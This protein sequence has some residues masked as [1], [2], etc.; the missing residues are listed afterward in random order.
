LNVPFNQTKAL[1]VVTSA[2]KALAYYSTET[3]FLH[4]PN[5]K[6]PH[7]YD[8]RLQLNTVKNTVAA[9]GYKTDWDFNLAIADAFNR[10]WDGHTTLTANCLAAFSYNLP[11][12]IATLASDVSDTQTAYPTLITNY[13]FPVRSRI[14]VYT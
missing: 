12:S 5:P 11:F 9:G 7:D 8:I 14:L 2:I 13:D 3:W 1:D 6:I 4:S 10:E